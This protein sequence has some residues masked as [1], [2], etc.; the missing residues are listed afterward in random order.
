MR[1]TD[2]I[3]VMDKNDI[4]HIDDYNAPI[5]HMNIFAGPV[6]EIPWKDPLKKMQVLSVV[7]LGDKICVLAAK[8]S[9]RRCV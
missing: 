8:N 2:L 6:R 7:A 4:I 3:H 9:K 5:D 1:I